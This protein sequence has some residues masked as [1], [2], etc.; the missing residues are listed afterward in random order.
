[1]TPRKVSAEPQG[2]MIGTG[3]AASFETIISTHRSKSAPTRSILLTNAMPGDAVA[4]GL[5]PDRLGLRLDAGDRVEHRDGAV[6][7]A[8]RALHLGREVDVA[9]ACR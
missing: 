7:D 3:L 2:M 8:E 6:E 9:R 1:M 4:V 5:A